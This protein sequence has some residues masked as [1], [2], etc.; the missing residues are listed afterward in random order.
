MLLNAA[1]FHDF[2]STIAAGIAQANVHPHVTNVRFDFR[3]DVG[4]QHLLF[5][6]THNCAGLVPHLAR[7]NYHHDRESRNS[8]K[9]FM[10]ILQISFSAAPGQSAYGI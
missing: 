4:P 3:W 8:A 9:Y 2:A 7:W 10:G 1:D 6:P 5:G